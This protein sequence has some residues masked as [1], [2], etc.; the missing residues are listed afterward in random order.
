MNSPNP[1]SASPSTGACRDKTGPHGATGPLSPS[2]FALVVF[3]VLC[4]AASATSRCTAAVSHWS[5]R[6]IE[7]VRVPATDDAWIS[8]PIDAFIL[9][10]LHRKGLSP[11][12]PADRHTLVRRMF[13]VLHGIPPGPEELDRFH[14]AS[15]E[16]LIDYLLGSPRYGERWAQHWLDVIRWAE[17]AGFETN[18][19][20][21][22]A[23]PYRDWV[24]ASLNA[25]KP[26][27]R[28][29][30]EQIAG[31]TVGE[32]AA[33]GFL[34]AGPANLP[35]QI[36]RDE[37][38]MRQARQDELD[39][40]LRTVGQ[41]FMGLTLG[42]ARCHDHKFDPI[43]AKDYYQTQAV[44]AGLSYGDRRLRGAENTRWTAQV[45]QAF[46]RVRALREQL[47][48]LRTELQLEPPLRDV[49]EDRFAP[50]EARSVRME[51]LAT[52]GGSPASLY[53]FEIW[54]A[55]AN[56]E[57]SVNVA[58]AER[59]ATASASGFALENQTRH[60][61]NL[62]D[63]E[64]D[65]RQAFPWKADKSGPAWIQIDLQTPMQIDRVVWHRGESVP[66]N[67]DISVQNTDGTWKRVAHSRNRLPRTDDMRKARDVHLDG[68]TAE[69]TARV[70][71]LI[72]KLRAAQSEHAR[73][74]A[75]P[76]VHAAVFSAPE[77]TWLLS[78]GDPMRRVESV[79]A[80][81]PAVLGTL[82]LPT[83]APEAERRIALAQ[84]LTDPDHPLTARVIVN[85]VWQ[86]YFGEGLVETPSDFGRMGAE[87][88]H[89][90]LLD[91]LARQFIEERWS[92][93]RLHRLIL[94]SSTF[95][96]SSSPNRRALA[97]DAD[98]RLLWRFPPRRVEA[99]VIRDSVLAVSGKLNPKMFGPGF[100][101]FNQ[102][103]GLSDYVPVEAFN[104]E[105]WRRMVYATKIRMQPVDIFGTFD[106]P[107]AGQ[108][109]PKRPRST[110]PIQALSLFNSPFIHRQA[111]WFA[112]R[113]ESESG[114]DLRDQIAYAL[115]L[116]FSRPPFAHE[117]DTLAGMAAIHG[118][119]PVCRALLNANE[120]VYLQ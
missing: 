90:E 15:I 25:D 113:V 97:V 116:A 49:E 92:L 101:F 82:D 45:P 104:H 23:W 96:Q 56:G 83:N 107:D 75:G 69:Q 21:P 66:A 89:P 106:C 33:L 71:N 47:E 65:A 70:V 51:I 73:L 27:D 59:G 22:N 77:T 35:G 19:P 64:I 29:L 119:E 84:H 36:G 108:M 16:S 43:T 24:I 6:P 60:P 63:G 100:D 91:W 20:R 39:E 110:T 10:Q 17:T 11:S 57:Q 55:G 37:E 72:S 76:Q 2:R 9:S 112:R 102:K 81:V 120:F 34:V 12:P 54:T 40:V 7:P 48:R 87:P 111:A 105:G 98:S 18:N 13:L 85:R 50:V 103:G 14:S 26:Y 78:R 62:N 1:Y 80:N 74:A 86:H 68:A 53:E 31:D 109:S 95:R 79:H 94:T 38:S 41:A 8:N 67:Y 118:L 88:S 61:D 28:F 30:F 99:E 117:L 46:E 114:A 42:C 32:D 52:T 3:A 5:L 44:F 4:I 93:K 115:Q 58:L